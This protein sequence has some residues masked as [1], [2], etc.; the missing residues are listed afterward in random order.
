MWIPSNSALQTKVIAALHSSAIGGHSGIKATYFRVKQLFHWKVLKLDVENYVKQC[1]V[2]QQA[3][4]ETNN[5]AGLL[6]PLPVPQGAWKDWSMDFIEALPLSEGSN[7]ILVVVDRFTKYSHFIPLRHPFTAMQVAKVVFDNVIKLH[8]LPNTIVSDRDKIFTSNFWK[9][10]FTLLN[11]KLLMS[12]AYHPQTGGQTERVNQCLEMYLRCAVHDSPKQWRTWLPLAELWYNTSFHSSLGCSPFK[13]LYGYEAPLGLVGPLSSQAS[14]PAEEFLHHREQHLSSLKTHLVATQNRMK[15]QADRHRTNRQFQVGEQ[16][17]L[18]LQPYA[19]HSVVN[20]P[21]PKLAYKFYG[22]F[23]ILEKIGVAAYKLAL[24]AES[25]IHPVFHV[26]Q[27]KPFIPCYTPV[28]AELPQVGDLTTQELEPEHILACRLVKKGNRAITQVLVKWKQVPATSATWEDYQVV[29][30][31]FP[32]AV[33]WGQATPEA[34]GDVRPSEQV[35]S[36]A[37]S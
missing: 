7:T 23:R 29:K 21:F 35:T 4:H 27:L 14:S 1:S 3:K 25:A 33:A 16:V 28:F 30:H 8:G 12:T 10:L 11:T 19:Q 13:A 9:A 2:C 18:K 17:L 26:S 31:R 20:R 6:Q 37:E 5:P 24:P 32:D 36:V 15:L 34:G 22:P